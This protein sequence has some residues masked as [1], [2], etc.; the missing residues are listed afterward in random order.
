MTFRGAIFDL[1]GTLVDSMPCWDTVGSRYLIE[2]NIPVPEDLALRLKTMTLEEAAV[3]YR[4]DFGITESVKEICDGISAMITRD[5]R[6]RIPLKPDIL[7]V[8]DTLQSHA[9][10]MCVCTATPRNL[11][12]PCLERLGLTPYF[13]FVVTCGDY[14][15]SK[16][17]PD[18]FDIC[19]R[20]LGTPKADTVVF[21]DSIHCARTLY[22]AG[23]RTVG[24]YDDSAKTEAKEMRPLCEAYLMSWKEFHYE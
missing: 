2:R 5:Y 20:R 19:T 23:Y 14:H 11:V 13:D 15:T 24:I 16:N 7:P 18:I 6:E 4:Q 1:D 3:F 10:R 22:R 8:L 12:L 21:E 9:V 17:Q